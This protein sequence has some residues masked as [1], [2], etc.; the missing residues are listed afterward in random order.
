MKTKKKT[1]QRQRRKTRARRVKRGGG[2]GLHQLI[3]DEKQLFD[4]LNVSGLT[5]PDLRET[6]VMLD[7][8]LQMLETRMLLLKQYNDV[9]GF[10][11]IDSPHSC[12]L[13]ED[14]PNKRMPSIHNIVKCFEQH[15]EIINLPY[16]QSGFDAEKQLHKLLKEFIA[17]MRRLKFNAVMQYEFPLFG[18]SY[19]LGNALWSTMNEIHEL[20]PGVPLVLTDHLRE[21]IQKVDTAIIA[22]MKGMRSQIDL[23]RDIKTNAIPAMEKAYREKDL[24]EWEHVLWETIPAFLHPDGDKDEF[25]QHMETFKR[26][27]DDAIAQKVNAMNSRVE[28][29]D[30]LNLTHLSHRTA[31]SSYTADGVLQP[32]RPPSHAVAQTVT[33]IASYD[34]DIT[35]EQWMRMRRG[36]RDTLIRKLTSKPGQLPIDHAKLQSK[37]YHTPEKEKIDP[38]HPD[39]AD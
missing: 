3:K 27:I 37:F 29:V 18:G 19:N 15:L 20:H 5:P 2:G 23:L 25:R 24:N 31:P 11:Y 39:N 16:I 1:N 33:D 38:P 6:D 12:V 35:R 10:L 7:K 14:D 17:E 22:I 34:P 28:F 21:I 26:K 4:L 32:A 9:Y 30:P 8:V 36:M 13:H